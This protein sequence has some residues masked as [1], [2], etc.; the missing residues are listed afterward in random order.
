MAPQLRMKLDKM[1]VKL[2]SEQWQDMRTSRNNTGALIGKLGSDIE[3]VQGRVGR[4]LSLENYYTQEKK[5]KKA[6]RRPFVLLGSLKTMRH[7]DQ[8]DLQRPVCK[9]QTRV[10]QLGLKNRVGS[11]SEPLPGSPQEL[12]GSADGSSSKTVFL[13]G[14]SKG[15]DREGWRRVSE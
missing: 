3:R 1:L 14:L 7:P 5:S 10:D 6:Q 9:P 4:K 13:A 2:F 11:I 15:H 8:R 12:S